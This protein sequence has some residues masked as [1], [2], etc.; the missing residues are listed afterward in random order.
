MKVDIKEG[1]IVSIEDLKI[2]KV[3]LFLKKEVPLESLV[4]LEKTIAFANDYL[5]DEYI[6]EWEE[7]ELKNFLDGCTDSQKVFLR[8]LSDKETMSTD[9]MMEKMEGGGID[10]KGS[11]RVL[12]A[13]PARVLRKS[14]RLNKAKIFEKIKPDGWKMEDRYLEMVKRIVSE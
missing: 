8:I 9:E 11:K 14:N 5:T 12:G 2:G 1:K 6:E 13:I 4:E 10:L 3:D 7:D